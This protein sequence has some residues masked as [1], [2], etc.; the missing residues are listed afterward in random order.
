MGNAVSKIGKAPR[1]DWYC[2]GVLLV[3]EEKMAKK[4]WGGRFS[5]K[6]D[7]LVEEF[8]KSIQ[9]DY[10]LAKA[11][12]AGSLFHIQVL[13]KCAYLSAGEFN[14]LYK[15]LIDISHS[16]DKDTFKCDKDSEDVHTNIQ[17]ILSKKVGTLA[18]KLHTARSRNDQVV[19][20]TKVYCKLAISEICGAIDGF[21]GAIKQSISKNNQVI[22]PGFTHLQHAQPVYLKDYL[23]VYTEMLNRDNNRLEYISKNIKLTLG[24]GALAGTPINAELYNF[25]AGV[26]ATSNSLDSVSDRDFVME[27][28][29]AL[30]IIAMHLSRLSEDLIIWSTKEF[31][32]VEIDEAF[33]TGSSLMP[34]KKNAD[35]LEL[36]RGYAGRLYGNLVS[37]LTMMK[38][39]PLTYNRDMQLDKEPLFNSFE[40]VSSELKVLAGLIKTLKFNKAKIE[41]HL[42]DEGLYATDIVYYLVDK[43]IPFKE[44]HTIVGKLVK[45]SLDNDIEIKAMPE[46]LLKKFSGKFVKKEVI[47]LFDP[48]VSVK[49]KK[50]IKR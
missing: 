25:K 38:G 7:P 37:V 35:V 17:N 13:K 21:I 1:A 43:K 34:Q 33:C 18:L 48:L 20:S 41:E 32:F 15:A 22:L 8:T 50:S 23:G 16:L 24:A 11:D 10:K 3:E 44:A 28:I 9:Y 6:T 46:S 36:V 40:I 2:A 47:K 12:I 30:S 29:S 39:L 26:H 31:D 27:I 5:K 45:Y 49:S 19:F 4:L 42:K 14:K